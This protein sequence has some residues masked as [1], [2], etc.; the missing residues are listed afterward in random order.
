MRYHVRR[1][2]DAEDELTRLWLR[3]TDRATVTN[4]ARQIDARLAA[5]A[6]N[7]GESRTGIRR[8]VFESPLGATYEIH[9]NNVYVLHVWRFRVG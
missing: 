7:L 5:N 8:I 4:A 6:P 1:S 9:G 3:T 2:R